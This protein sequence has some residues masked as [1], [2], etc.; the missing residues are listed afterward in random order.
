ML[1]AF[2]RN[3]LYGTFLFL[4]YIFLEPKRA[5]LFPSVSLYKKVKKG[6]E[7]NDEFICT[8]CMTNK[9]TDSKNMM[10]EKN[11]LDTEIRESRKTQNSM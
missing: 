6:N 2:Q 5:Y 7:Y 1:T 9:R 11:R 3:F 8:Y 10:I 4:S